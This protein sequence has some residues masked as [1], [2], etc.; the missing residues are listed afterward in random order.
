MNTTKAEAVQDKGVKK[1]VKTVKVK[2][3]LDFL[4]EPDVCGRCGED[5]YDILGI[6]CCSKCFS[7]PSQPTS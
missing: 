3:S 7:P 6:G 2:N 1:R 4:D 5:Y